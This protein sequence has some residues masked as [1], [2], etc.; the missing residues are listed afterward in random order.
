[1]RYNYENI[2]QIVKMHDIAKNRQARQRA[3]GFL[4]QI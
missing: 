4:I 3:Q 1:M 2:F